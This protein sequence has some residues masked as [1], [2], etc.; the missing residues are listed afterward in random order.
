MLLSKRTYKSTHSHP[1]ILEPPHPSLSTVLRKK[2]KSP[3]NKKSGRGWNR[4]RFRQFLYWVCRPLLFCLLLCTISLSP[5]VLGFLSD[6]LI[7]QA[8]FNAI[9]YQNDKSG[10]CEIWTHDL[11]QLSQVAL[12]IYYIKIHLMGAIKGERLKSTRS[13]FFLSFVACAVA[14]KSSE[15]F[16][17]T[18]NTYNH[19]TCIHTVFPC[20]VS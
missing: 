3:G 6:N 14:F 13:T 7:E 17:K 5:E 1:K 18:D 19:Y 8:Q 16:R 20:Q 12:S 9:F 2:E 4:Q 11:S 10:L 15:V